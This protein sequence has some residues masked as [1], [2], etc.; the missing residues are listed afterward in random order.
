I[1][2]QINTPELQKALADNGVNS[3]DF[4]SRLASGELRNF[5]DIMAAINSPNDFTSDQIAD[6][7]ARASAFASGSIAGDPEK[8]GKTE[9]ARI[10]P[11]D[12]QKKF[13]RPQGDFGAGGVTVGAAA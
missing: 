11:D 8:K 1:K 3:D 2:Q 4:V 6:A 9:V 13:E 12:A 7:Q 10:K 5:E